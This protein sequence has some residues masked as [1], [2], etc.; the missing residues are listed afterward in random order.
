MIITLDSRV[1]ALLFWLNMADFWS[2]SLELFLERKLCNWEECGDVQG[3]DWCCLQGRLKMF[4]SGHFWDKMARSLNGQKSGWPD[5][6]M[7]RSPDGKM[8]KSL[9]VWCLDGQ[10]SGCLDVWIARWPYG[11]MGKCPDCHMARCPDAQNAKI[12]YKN[13][14]SN[15]SVDSNTPVTPLTSS[16]VTSLCDK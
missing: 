16:L 5:I 1:R 7:A 13:I 9:V 15:I 10:K 4:Q 8:T 3:G 6:R 2:V 11:W 12:S 14:S